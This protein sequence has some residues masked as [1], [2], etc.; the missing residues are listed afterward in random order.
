METTFGYVLKDFNFAKQ[1]VNT[2]CTF[3]TIDIII[4]CTI[5]YTRVYNNDYKHKETILPSRT[6][7]CAFSVLISLHTHSFF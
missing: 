3:S 6:F 5:Q 7:C 4:T 1:N 2:F